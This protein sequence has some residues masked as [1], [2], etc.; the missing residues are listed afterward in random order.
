MPAWSLPKPSHPPQVTYRKAPLWSWSE[1][2]TP[3]GRTRKKTLAHMLRHGRRPEETRLK[4]HLER[5][6]VGERCAVQENLWRSSACGARAR[7]KA[8][9]EGLQ[10]VTANHHWKR[11]EV[12]RVVFTTPRSVSRSLW[13]WQ[14]LV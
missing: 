7:L 6:S 10:P 1:I 4:L 9:L 3:N 5:I 13:G 12:D 2:S 14:G 8:G 11:E